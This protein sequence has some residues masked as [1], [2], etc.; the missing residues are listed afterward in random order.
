MYYYNI[1][2]FLSDLLLMV[3]L[4]YFIYAIYSQHFYNKHIKK[5]HQ[6]I[7][8]VIINEK[9]SRNKDTKILIE[10]THRLVK[11]NKPNI[12]V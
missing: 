9:I 1:F 6:E 7:S 3:A 5:I 10:Y 11:E 4:I 2:G 8:E 12:E